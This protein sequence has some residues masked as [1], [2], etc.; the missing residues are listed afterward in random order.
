M[1]YPANVAELPSYM[2]LVRYKHE[3]FTTNKLR[4]PDKFQYKSSIGE[5]ISL[6]VPNNLSDGLTLQWNEE[7]DASLVGKLAE[8]LTDRT[9]ILKAGKKAAFMQSGT[10][11]EKHTALLFNGVG[12]KTYTFNWSLTPETKQEADDIAKIVYAFEEA[13][14]PSLKAGGEMFGYPDLWKIRFGGKSKFKMMKF[15]PV[16]LTNISYN[17][18]PDGTFLIYEDGNI[19]SIKISLTFSEITSRNRESFKALR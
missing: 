2:T 14:L 9:A 13:S 4:R 1:R 10:A 7:G 18:S 8:N 17:F 6:P 11:K 15:L 3:G 5:V 19:P 16:I 12:T